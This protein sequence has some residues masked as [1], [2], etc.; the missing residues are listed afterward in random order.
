MSASSDSRLIVKAL[1]RLFSLYLVVT[2]DAVTLQRPKKV[3]FLHTKQAPAG[4]TPLYIDYGPPQFTTFDNATSACKACIEFFPAKN[5][6]KRFHSAMYEDPNGGVWE[7]ACRAGKCDFMDPQLDPV[8]GI[9]GHGVGPGGKPDGKTCITRD[10][11][12]WYSDCETVL[13]DVTHT[14]LDVTRYCSYREQVFIPPPLNTVSF[15]AGNPQAWSRI[16]GPKEQCL[17]SIEKHGAALFDT[18][19]FCDSDLPTLSGCC[20]TVFSALTCVGET[21][22]TRGIGESAMFTAMGQDAAHMMSVFQKYCA[23]LCQG[24]KEDFCMRYPGADVCVQHTTCDGCT[25]QG[26][27]WC[28]KL[29]SCHCPS[30]KPPCI[31]PPVTTPLQCRELASAGLDG[32]DGSQSISTDGTGDGKDGAGGSGGGSG[33]SGGAAGMCK[34]AEFARK[35]N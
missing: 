9:I 2:T 8:G 19:S 3:S 33:E 26:G 29:K 13:L 6:G 23:P 24:S 15:F 20:E 25:G 5:D 34:Y 16:G 10:P 18:M 17:T 12:Q 28:P 7:Q 32:S 4:Q 31:A 14:P 30:L 27:I 35:W 11:V 1:L 22:T 21:A